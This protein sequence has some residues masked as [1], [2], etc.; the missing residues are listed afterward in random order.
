MDLPKYHQI[1]VAIGGNVTTAKPNGPVVID[2]GAAIINADN[3]IITNGFEVRKGASL[4]IIPTQ[5]NN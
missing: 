2:R 1:N 3:V 5:L 4:E